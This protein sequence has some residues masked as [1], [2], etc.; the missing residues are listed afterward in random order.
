MS[1][2]LLLH[3]DILEVVLEVE[4]MNAGMSGVV[5]AINAPRFDLKQSQV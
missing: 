1:K 5:L 3:N 2:F 4:V